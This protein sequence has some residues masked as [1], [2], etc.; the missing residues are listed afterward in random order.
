LWDYPASVG[1]VYMSP[2][3][4]W[5]WDGSQKVIAEKV[6]VKTTEIR[7]L[8]SECESLIHH[9]V[10]GWHFGQMKV[11]VDPVLIFC[12][13]VWHT[14]QGFPSLYAILNCSGP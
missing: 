10:M 6:R 11:L 3:I 1:S 7:L 5:R 13:V 8:K 9:L 2:C 12:I 14:G 4:R